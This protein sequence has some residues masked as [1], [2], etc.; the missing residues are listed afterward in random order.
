MAENIKPQANPADY[1]PNETPVDIETLVKAD[2]KKKIRFG[3]IMGIL[4][5]LYWGVWYVPGYAVWGMNDFL[6]PDCIAGLGGAIL[7]KKD[8][9]TDTAY[10]LECLFLTC[11]NA[12]AC[13]LVL[14]IWNGALGKLPEFK[15]TLCEVKAASKYFM[16]AGICGACAVSGTYIAAAFLSPGFAAVAG[17]LYPII[18]TIMSVLYLK[19]KVSKRGYLAI[20]VLLAGGI[21]LYAGSMITGTDS[22]NPALGALGGIMAAVGWGFEGVVAGKALD[23]CE[24]D[25]GLHLRFCFEAVFWWIV[26]AVLMIAGFPMMDTIGEIADPSIFLVVLLLGLSFAWCYVTWY[27]SF[28]FLGVAR[29]QA[30]GSLYAACA[31]VFLIIFFGPASALGYTDSTSSGDKAILIGS[32]IAGLIICLIGSFLIAT[33]DSEGMVSLRDSGGSE[34][35]TGENQEV[36]SVKP[37]DDQ[38][39]IIKKAPIKFRLMQILENGGPMWSYEVVDKLCQEYNM[40]SEH[41]RH[42]VNYD[43]I[44]MTSAGFLQELEHKVDTEGKL[45]KDHLL[46]RYGITDLGIT[47]VDGLKSEVRYYE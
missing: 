36:N 23:I 17:L 20:I 34:T 12:T 13:A 37:I 46:V 38:G 40:S 27:K 18:G 45:N 28:P 33:E 42:M 32:T 15:R 41:E 29:G 25:V 21:T 14:F 22:A 11:I 16:L 26:M 4:C 10:V 5:A 19:Q 43:L 6:D 9:S 1:R 31:V 2:H 8:V 35:T 39:K 7:E 3:L 44:E 47:T 24:P 30:V